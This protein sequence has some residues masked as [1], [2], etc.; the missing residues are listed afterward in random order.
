M[1]VVVN[2]AARDLDYNTA[3]GLDITRDVIGGYES[4]P[5]DEDGR[6]IMTEEQYDWWTDEINKLVE[7]DQLIEDLEIKD[8]LFDQYIM[9]TSG[10]DL[11]GETDM[12]LA[13][14]HKYQ[15]NQ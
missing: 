10:S 4:L 6:W 7:I 2:G 3:S 15:S 12:Q 1:V 9:E 8:E 13:W 5:C 14:L 11:E